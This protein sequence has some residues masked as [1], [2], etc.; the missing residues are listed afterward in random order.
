[1]ASVRLLIESIRSFG[2]GLSKSPIWLFQDV[3][4]SDL[5]D[6]EHETDVDVLP[7]TVRESIKDHELSEKVWACA[8]VERLSAS[9][10]RSLVW[11]SPDTLIVNPPVL[12]ELGDMYD[13]ALRPVHIKNVGLTTSEPSTTQSWALKI[14]PESETSSPATTRT[15]TCRN[16]STV[17]L[18][19]ARDRSAQSDT[20]CDRL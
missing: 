11:L 9:N 7:M 19:Q 18:R 17:L 14:I 15:T 20:R 1:M 4:S 10:V 8:E 13:A 5:A 2:G 3:A 6:I 12:Y 16:R